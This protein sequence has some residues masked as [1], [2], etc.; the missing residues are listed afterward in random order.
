MYDLKLLEHHPAVRLNHRQLLHFQPG[1][2]GCP[3]Y[4]LIDANGIHL[5]ASL[6]G[7]QTPNK[8]T[9]SQESETGEVRWQSTDAASR[10][11]W[12]LGR[13]LA[14]GEGGQHR[15]AEFHQ[16]RAGLQHALWL[17]AATLTTAALSTRAR[18]TRHY[19]AIPA[20]DIYYNNNTTF[21]RQIAGYGEVSY[22]FT[23]WMKLTVGERVA[24]TEFSLTHYADGFENY[25]P[26]PG[27]VYANQKQTPSTP[28]ATL[29]FQVDP[30]DLYYVD[31]GEGLPRG[32]R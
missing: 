6:H 2:A 31:L 7:T 32:R 28:K 11:S 19:P 16:H 29:A 4:P 23:D 30:R 27:I 3:W 17:H 21:D 25:G 8:M 14:A 24:H 5:P 22:A 1:P 13:V 10:W 26:Y 15:G 9:N 12:T 18:R 20:C